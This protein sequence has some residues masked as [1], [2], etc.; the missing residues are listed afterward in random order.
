MLT[1]CRCTPP[2]Q[3]VDY[4][5]IIDTL[6]GTRRNVEQHAWFP[7]Y[8]TE[9]VIYYQDEDTRKFHVSCER[10]VDFYNY[11]EMVSKLP[12]KATP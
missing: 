4:A 6:L 8:R 1:V 3:L 7:C 12:E 11:K 5:I 10:G 2:T 9:E